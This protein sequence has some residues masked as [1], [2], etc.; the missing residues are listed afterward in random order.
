MEN[1]IKEKPVYTPKERAARTL[2][3]ITFSV[4]MG[5]LAI[6][7]ISDGIL[8]SGQIIGFVIACLGSALVFFLGCIA[9]LFSIVL[10][11]GVYLIK[12]NGFWPGTWAKNTFLEVMRDYTLEPTQ[13]RAL[14][15]IRLVLVILCILG[16][17]AAIVTLALR[18]AAKKDN[19]EGKQKLTTTFGVLSL[20]FSILGGFAAA[21]I[22]LIMSAVK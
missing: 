16:F 4:V 19:P 1:E 18:K 14:V 8:F 13:I 10:I 12:Q 22:I 11:F 2:A 9:M 6:A 15:T 7:L 21:V 5:A 17:I 20:I 3:I